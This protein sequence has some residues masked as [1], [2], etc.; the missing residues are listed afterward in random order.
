VCCIIICERGGDPRGGAEDEFLFIPLAHSLCAPLFVGD[1]AHDGKMLRV[2]VYGD[3]G[4]FTRSL[5]MGYF[6]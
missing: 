2:H 3:L 6:E 1:E 5:M 4:A